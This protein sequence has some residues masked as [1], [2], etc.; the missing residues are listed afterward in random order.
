MQLPFNDEVNVPSSNE[1]TSDTSDDGLLS[2]ALKVIQTML[3]DTV[4]YQ[5]V[6]DKN[7]SSLVTQAAVSQEKFCYFRDISNPALQAFY[8]VLQAVALHESI[9]DIVGGGTEG[10]ITD[11]LRPYYDLEPDGNDDDNNGDEVVKSEEDVTH[12]DG[13]AFSTL[14]RKRALLRFKDAA[15]VDDE[16]VVVPKVSGNYN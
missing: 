3:I 13:S 1:V 4:P 8:A 5:S 7:A 11:L 12:T 10:E 14:V 9:P 6:G 15:G 16:G 2:S